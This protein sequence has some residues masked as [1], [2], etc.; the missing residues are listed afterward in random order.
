MDFSDRL[1]F[2]RRCAG[3]TQAELGRRVCLSK[4]TISALE[5]GGASP[6]I[7]VVQR[8][9]QELGVRPLSLL[10]DLDGGDADA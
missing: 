9:A 5:N 6:T 2:A 1:L 3:L 10:I 8:I 7:L 4:A